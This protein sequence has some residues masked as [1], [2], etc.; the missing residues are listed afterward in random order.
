MKTPVIE[1]L[2]VT[3]GVVQITMQDRIHKNTFSSELVSGL[4]EAFKIIHGNPAFKVAILTG[5]DN[6]FCS[7]GTEEGILA[8][9]DGKSKF[10]DNNLY[11]LAMECD[12]PVI[13]AMQGHGI[14]GGFVFGLF[15]DYVVLGREC[16]Y[17]AN[18][19]KYGITPGMGATFIVPKKLGTGLGMEVLLGAENYR[20]GELEKRGL[21]FPVLPKNEVV[22]YARLKALHLAD[23]P[24]ISL[25]TLKQH[26]VADM[27][28]ELAAVIEKELQM[29]EITFHRPEVKD[30]IRALYGR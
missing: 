5:Y 18:F 27:R 13:A 14:G 16:I 7:G 11:S 10:T 1:L 12:I 15:A 28:T 19:M 23:K 2:E 26:L 20:G 29:H 30:R 17:T 24:R 8:M 3:P 6:Y 22:K 9:A 25:V 4:A 21:P